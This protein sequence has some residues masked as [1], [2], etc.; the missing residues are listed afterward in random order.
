MVDE[1][2]LREPEQ[3]RQDCAAKF[4]PVMGN[5]PFTANLV[6][7]DSCE[8]RIEVIGSGP[9]KRRWTRL[10]FSVRIATPQFVQ[11]THHCRQMNFEA[12]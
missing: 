4:R 2:R 3:I 5:G 7:G 6:E 9:R 1:P 8:P 11:K 10:T 12:E